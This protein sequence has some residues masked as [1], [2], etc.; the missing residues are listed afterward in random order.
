MIA[1]IGTGMPTFILGPTQRPAVCT[2]VFGWRVFPETPIVVA[3]NRDE[4]LDREASPPTVRSGEPRVLAPRDEMAGGTWM[5]VNEEGVFAGLTNRWVDADLPAER[6]RGRLVDDLL[7]V[8][9]AAAGVEVVEDAVRN[10][11]YDG[12]NVIVAD[13][14]SAVLLEYDGSISQRDLEEGVHVL[15]NTG[16]DGDY[17]VPSHRS[18]LAWTQGER[19]DRV[20]AELQPESKESPGA[21]LDR[22]KEV[23]GDHDFGVCIHGDGY[24]TVS[25]S[26]LSIKS[27]GTVEYRYADGPPC[28]TDA[29]PV[30][31]QL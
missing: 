18:E 8:R 27:D 24:G 10:D 23:L 3:A 20:R 26:L 11:S 28:R 7:R 9:S 30:D 19:A 17:D 25:T 21:W 12:F 16:A 6:S 15:V 1:P 14:E 5:G 4:R 13:T 29:R 31:N 22:G 2:V